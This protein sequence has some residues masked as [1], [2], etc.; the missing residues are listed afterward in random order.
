MEII[1]RE[2]WGAAFKDGF[3]TAETPAREVWLHHSVTEAPD[4]EPPFDDEHAAV[5]LLEEIGEKRFKRG[6]SYTFVVMPTGRVYEGHSVT[7]QGSHL[8]NRNGIA[9]AIVWV[10]NYDTHSPTRQQIE[11]TANLLVFG[12]QQ[13]WWREARLNGGHGQAPGAST[14]CPGRWA[15]QRIPEVNQLAAAGGTGSAPPPEEGFMAQISDADAADV[16][17]A[18]KSWLWGVAGQR[19]AGAN[20]LALGYVHQQVTGLSAAVKTLTELLAAGRDDVTA[21]EFRTVLR[22]EMAKV[23]QVE[24]SVRE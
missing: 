9:R 4:L 14:A 23:V 17:E 18:A 20:V 7:R 24:V 19:G 10:G 21:E 15:G 6:I 16:V 12:K 22:D 8:A 2:Q 3:G 11:A 1:Q 13:G 5:R